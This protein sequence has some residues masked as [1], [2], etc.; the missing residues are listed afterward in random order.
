MFGYPL[1]VRR[2]NRP[3]D[4]NQSCNIGI[5]RQLSHIARRYFAVAKC[6]CLIQNT[7]RIAHTATRQPGYLGNR[8]R[9]A[10]VLFAF[11]NVR[12][13]GG[14]DIARKRR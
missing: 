9:F 3:Q 10:L 7:Q 5:A 2:R 12:Q 8:R 11:E 6:Q 1:A 4:S 14:N 13:S